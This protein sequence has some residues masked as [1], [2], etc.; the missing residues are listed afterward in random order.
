LAFHLKA[1]RRGWSLKEAP[2]KTAHTGRQ[3][4]DFRSMLCA[5]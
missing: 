4:A 5:H 1:M 3:G 2:A